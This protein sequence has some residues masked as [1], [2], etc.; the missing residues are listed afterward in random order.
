MNFLDFTLEELHDKL[1]S[2]ELTAVDLVETSYKRIEETDEQVGAFLAL[3]KE[4]ALQ[5]ARETDEKGIDPNNVL[6]GLP[7]GIKAGR[8]RSYL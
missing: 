5:A 4:E 6:S 3:S 2:K 8:L 7:V 1:V